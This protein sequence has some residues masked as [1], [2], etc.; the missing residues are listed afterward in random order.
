MLRYIRKAYIMEA[1]HLAT[2][3]IRPWDG[4]AV[5]DS[6]MP[7]KQLPVI[8]LSS[9]TVTES[10]ENGIRV[11]NAKFSCTL[12]EWQRIPL[13]PCCLK[14]VCSD[15]TE[16]LMGRNVRPFPLITQE[17]SCPDRVSERSICTLTAQLTGVSGLMGINELVK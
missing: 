2:A 5:I 3:T 13:R 7:W 12:A 11:K 8:G 14:L 6:Y 15:G 10:V 9:L 1:Y 16:W 17:L 4:V